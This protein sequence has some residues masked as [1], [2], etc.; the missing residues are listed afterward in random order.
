V[1]LVLTKE[2]ILTSIKITIAVII[3]VLIAQILNMDFHLSVATIVIVSMLSAKKQSLKLASQRLFSAIIALTLSS[4]LFLSLGFSFPVLMLFVFIFT[5][6][7]FKLDTKVAIVLNVVLVIHIYTLKEISLLILLN[8]FGLMALGIFV[9]LIVNS[10][11]LDIEGELIQYKDSAELIFNNVFNNMGKCL[12]NQCTNDTIRME[13]NELDILLQKA[14]SRAYDY[15][16]S[17]Y[18]QENN[19]YVEY[20]SMRRQQYHT[21]RLMQ[22]FLASNFL[23]QKEAIMLKD[24]TDNFINNTKVHN[25]CENQI[26]ILEEIKHHFTYDAQIPLDHQ[27]LQNRIALHQYLYSLEDLVKVKMR[28]IDKYEKGAVLK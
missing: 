20:F 26:E 6:L 25:M 1:G 16:N 8:E 10:F 22:K 9:A 15:M 14:K 3:G 13:L 17:Y 18:I 28:F 4:F 24:F 23:E 19:Y 2:N 12:D 21:V 27:Q 5:F 11:T 7:M